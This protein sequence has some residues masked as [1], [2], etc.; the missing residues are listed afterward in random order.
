M[1]ELNVE[2]KD[3]F[4]N[5]ELESATIEWSIPNTKYVGYQERYFKQQIEAEQALLNFKRNLRTIANKAHTKKMN[6]LSDEI[7][8]SIEKIEQ[9][10][11]KL[12]NETHK[13]ENK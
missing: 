7:M 2:I 5:D 6:N 1:K 11:T 13:E 3:L 4:I 10:K 8:N 9:L 12:Y